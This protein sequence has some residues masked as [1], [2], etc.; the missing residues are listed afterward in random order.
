MSSRLKNKLQVTQNKIVRYI[1]NHNHRE[2]VGQL[3]LNSLNFLSV[4]DRVAQLRLNHVY[5]IREGTSPVYLNEGF[6]QLSDIHDFQTRSRADNYF[7]P[8]VKG[9]ETET[10]YYTDI[11][12]WNCLP[13]E[14]KK[15]WQLQSF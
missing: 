11:K 5:R 14:V 7:V 13:N 10:F 4:R 9:V 1:L 15:L 6:C 2:H 8:Q 3:E 12:D